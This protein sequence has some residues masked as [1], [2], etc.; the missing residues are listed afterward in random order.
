M[1]AAKIQNVTVFSKE[2][3]AGLWE[4]IMPLLDAHW[5][6]IATYKDIP[7]E[8]N[9]AAYEEGERRGQFRAYTIREEGRLIGYAAYMVAKNLHYESALVAMQDVLYLDPK[10]RGRMIGARFIRW[11]DNQLADEGVTYVTQHVKTEHNWGALLAR[12]GYQHTENTW[13]RRLNHGD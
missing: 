11:C 13:T 2:S 12:L 7:L 4:E 5:Q 9:K 10:Y 3:V 6:E 1:H 8:V